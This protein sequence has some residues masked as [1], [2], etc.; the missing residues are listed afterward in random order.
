MTS[1]MMRSLALLLTRRSPERVHSILKLSFEAIRECGLE[2]PP[3]VREGVLQI[4]VEIRPQ[5]RRTRQYRARSVA[6]TGSEQ[7]REAS[8]HS[9]LESAT[10][11]V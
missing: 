9:C 7:E 2:A 10:L 4:G 8:H 1:T 3:R 6:G 11:R 5:G